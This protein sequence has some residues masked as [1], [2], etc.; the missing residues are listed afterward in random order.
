MLTPYLLASCLAAEGEDRMSRTA[1]AESFAFPWFSPLLTLCKP[2][3]IAWRMFCDRVT[4]SRLLGELFSLL[5]SIWLTSR[6]VFGFGTNARAIRAWTQTVRCS[7]TGPI[8]TCRYP[9]LFLYAPMG[10]GLKFAQG[11]HFLFGK[12]RGDVLATCPV[13]ETE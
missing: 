12:L 2:V 9:P 1:S 3:A 11:S 7:P 6:P 10:E 4:H 13:V 5:P 8:R